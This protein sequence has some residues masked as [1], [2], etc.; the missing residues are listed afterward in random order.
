MARS[1]GKKLGVVFWLSLLW[2][3]FVLCAA[4][5]ADLW[6]VPLHD[7][8]DWANPAA[9]PGILADTND[10]HL[11]GTDSMGRDTLARLLYGAR[12]SLSVGLFAPLIGMLIGGGLGILAGYFRGRFSALL[13]GTMDALLAFPALVLL[14]TV[15]YLLGANLLNIT[16]TLGLLV[17][18]AFFRVA[19]ANTLRIVDLQFVQA[20][21]ISGAGDAAIILREILPNVLVPVSVFALLVVGYMIIAEGGLGFLGLS[22]PIP[23]PSWGGMVAEGRGVL[24]EAPHVSLIPMAVMFLTILSFN[25]LGDRLRSLT[26]VRESRL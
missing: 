15:V 10:I 11:F 14:L 22:V 4:L 8:I 5:T 16:L 2:I 23:T 20:A 1:T 19:R 7:H 12:V 21:R 25:L 24:R 13:V 6:P 18:P 9:L 26:D 17:T 3:L